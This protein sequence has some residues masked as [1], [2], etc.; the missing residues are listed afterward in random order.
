[1]SSELIGRDRG[2]LAAS[3]KD[4]HS[5]LE[6]LIADPAE[7]RERGA[8][9]REFVEREYSYQRWAPELAALLHSVAG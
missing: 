5:A 4:W 7:R 1:V 3:P 6:R 8:A 9:A 2:L